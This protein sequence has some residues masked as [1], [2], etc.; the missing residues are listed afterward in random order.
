MQADKST[1]VDE[2]VNYIKTLEQTVQKLEKQK[3]E[4]VQGVGTMTTSI[5]SYDPSQMKAVGLMES[6]REAF[7]AD[8]G[9]TSSTLLL[10]HH[11]SSNSFSNFSR[12]PPPPPPPP[13]SPAAGAAVF[14]TWVSP[15]VIL[16]VCGDNAHINV[17]C[18]KRL[19]LFTAITFFL[20][21]NKLEVVSAQVSSDHYRTM[22]MIQVQVLSSFLI[23]QSYHKNNQP[24]TI[25]L[26]SIQ[27]FSYIFLKLL[28]LL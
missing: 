25:Y 1:I 2:A 26:T 18:P 5:C 22:F 16:N 6:S 11:Q 19:G 21:K 10:N 4:R 3:V 12:H 20:E 15:N 9:S 7:L 28:Q 27:I 8:Q 14:R 24:V 13:P 17:C 23:I